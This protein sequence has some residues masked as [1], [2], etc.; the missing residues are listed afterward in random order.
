[1]I[2]ELKAF[3]RAVESRRS[4]PSERYAGTLPRSGIFL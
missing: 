1:M 3:F 4:R 2:D